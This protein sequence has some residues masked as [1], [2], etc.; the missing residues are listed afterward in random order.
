MAVKYKYFPVFLYYTRI[1][2]KLKNKTSFS[3]L[4]DI[5]IYSLFML[6]GLGSSS[7]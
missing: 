6:E 5:A 2:Y 1:L 4:R 3:N 7:I